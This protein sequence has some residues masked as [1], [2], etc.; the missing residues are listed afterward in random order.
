MP[1]TSSRKGARLSMDER[2]RVFDLLYVINSGFH[3][4]VTSLEQMDEELK[5]LFSAERMA[6]L[7]EF[8]KE[9]Q[10]HINSYFLEV[11]VNLE[12]D[13]RDQFG[14]IRKAREEW[15]RFPSRKP[16]PDKP[17]EPEK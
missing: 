15:H 17:T 4:I 8:S 10:G 5:P 3:H 14:R 11:F 2:L 1:D 6:Q 9:T 13:D 7:Q 16:E 12:K